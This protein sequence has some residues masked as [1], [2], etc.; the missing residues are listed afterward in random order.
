MRGC[1]VE[2]VEVHWRCGDGGLEEGQT[3]ELAVQEDCAGVREAASSAG[4]VQQECRVSARSERQLAVWTARI[5][6][7]SAEQPSLRGWR[8]STAAGG[9]SQLQQCK[10]LGT[11][12]R[13]MHTMC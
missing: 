6:C 5:R 7:V 13:Q 3:R 8:E 2:V 10:S 1:G 11:N 12:S 9:A 4:A